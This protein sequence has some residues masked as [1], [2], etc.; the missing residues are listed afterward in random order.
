M[1]RLF[2]R[3]PNIMRGYVNPEANA[4]FQAL[5]GFDGVLVRC[6]HVVMRGCAKRRAAHAGWFGRPQACG[7]P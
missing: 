6:S 3:G 5:G 1:G 4:A 7:E 2:V